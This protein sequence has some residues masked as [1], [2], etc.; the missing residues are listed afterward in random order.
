MGVIMDIKDN[1]DLAWAV[2][3]LR[4]QGVPVDA[5]EEVLNR[6]RAVFHNAE[7]NTKMI[8]GIDSIPLAYIVKRVLFGKLSAYQAEE[9]ASYLINEKLFKDEF[10]AISIANKDTEEMYSL[11]KYDFDL[12]DIFIKADTLDQCIIDEYNNW[13][14]ID[15]TLDA[16][17]DALLS[18]NVEK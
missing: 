4:A 5:A 11:F 1:I 16:K 15:D 2:N 13:E 18:I 8:V 6:K 7:T 12:V 3:T 10:L 17:W 9:F 14:K